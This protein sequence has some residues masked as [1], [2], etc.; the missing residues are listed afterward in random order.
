M[1]IP[2]ATAPEANS[3]GYAFQWMDDVAVILLRKGGRMRAPYVR[4]GHTLDTDDTVYVTFSEKQ[5]RRPT[6]G[7]M[8]GKGRGPT[9]RWVETL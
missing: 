3:A 6:I 7:Y 8:A 1:D 2:A 9:R 5:I 4:G